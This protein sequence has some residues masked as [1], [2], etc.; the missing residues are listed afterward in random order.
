VAGRG[1]DLDTTAV[2]GDDALSDREAEPATVRLAGV[3]RL[4]HPR[5]T[6]GGN[7]GPGVADREGDVAILP[8]DLEGQ[9]A[10]AVH[11]LDAVQRDVP[12]HLDDLVAVEGEAWDGRVD[13]HAHVHA[14]RAR[15]VVA[16]QRAHVLHHL[17]DVAGRAPRLLGSGEVQEV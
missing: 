8:G 3:E 9:P 11:R 14:G 10:A 5:K 16:D 1:V 6:L 12:E 17:A 15:A 2:R 4:E 7:P 13:R